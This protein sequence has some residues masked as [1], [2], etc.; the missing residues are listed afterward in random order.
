M[1]VKPCDNKDIIT[2]L[3]PGPDGRTIVERHR[4][5]HS[6][7]IVLVEPARA[8]RPLAPGEEFA[9]T[10]PRGDGTHEVVSSYVR[11]A[12]KPAQVASRDYRCGWDRTFNAPGGQ[13]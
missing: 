6:T 4:P 2:P 12:G 3:G 7:E 13:A 5:G 10:E 1:P 9:R 11:P 8:G